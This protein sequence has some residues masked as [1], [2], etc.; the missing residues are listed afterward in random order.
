MTEDEKT[1]LIRDYE[2]SYESRV[3]MMYEDMI[4][5]LEARTGLEEDE[6]IERM[7]RR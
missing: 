6:I 4:G 2:R 3:E 5:E 7:D 1:A